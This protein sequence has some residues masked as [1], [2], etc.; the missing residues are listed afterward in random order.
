[1][2]SSAAVSSFWIRAALVPAT[3]PA[4][5]YVRDCYAGLTRVQGSSMEPTLR[6]GDVVLVRRADAGTLLQAWNGLVSSIGISPTGD[7]GLIKG[8]T[9]DADDDDD[10][11]EEDRALAIRFQ[12][13]QGIQSHGHM[14]WLSTSRPPLVLPGH[15]LVYQ[16]PTN[17]QKEYHIKRV[18]GVGGQWVRLLES[19]RPSR[20]E[21][22][23]ERDGTVATRTYYDRRLIAL[24]AHSIYVEGDNVSNS[25]DSRTTGP[26]SYNLVV[27]V[28]EYVIWPPS[29]WQRIQRRTVRD[30]DGSPRAIWY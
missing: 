27:G 16:N 24:P 23:M 30:V 2:A 17:L 28:A 15:V 26:I 6:H 13:L 5:L 7:E 8:R 11:D 14:G 19:P 4:V 9:E 22:G 12:R 25:V 1:M 18:V 29:R 3:L 21:T 20:H 10:D